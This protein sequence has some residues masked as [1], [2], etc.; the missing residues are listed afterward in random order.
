VRSA[1]IVAGHSLLKSAVSKALG[2][3]LNTL[4]KVLPSATLGKEHTVKKVVGKAAFAECFL[5]GTR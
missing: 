1:E 5:S 2:K 4:G 3:A